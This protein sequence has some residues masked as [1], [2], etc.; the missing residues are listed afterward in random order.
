MVTL[1]S[2]GDVGRKLRDRSSRVVTNVKWGGPGE[3]DPVS[4]TS[5]WQQRALP[6]PFQ[7]SACSAVV[8]PSDDLFV[9]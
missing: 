9:K 2:I 5:P 6:T 3:V 7:E 1:T 8:K 4:L